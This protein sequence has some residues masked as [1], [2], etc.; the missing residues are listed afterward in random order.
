MKQMQALRSLQGPPGCIII[1]PIWKSCRIF[2]E[3]LVLHLLC[4]SSVHLL[5]PL[6]YF[7]FFLVTLR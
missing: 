4:P 7:Q 1:L 3:Y 6:S 5:L 2:L